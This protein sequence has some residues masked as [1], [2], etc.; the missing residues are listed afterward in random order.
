MKILRLTLIALI[1]LC[2]ACE[3]DKFEF[4]DCNGD[5]CIQSSGYVYDKLTKEPITSARIKISYKENCGWCGTGCQFREFNIGEV[6]T[7]KSGY[8][9]T[10]FSSK[11]FD[12]ITGNYV[13]EIFY[14]DFIS[15]T[16]GISN[17]NQSELFFE[18]DLNPPAYLNLSVNLQNTLNIEYFGLSIYSDSLT[19]RSLGGYNSNESGLFTDTVLNF[20][21]PAERKIYYGYLIKTNNGEKYSNDSTII[22]SYKTKDLEINE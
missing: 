9:Q 18:A 11:E 12:G 19:A 20:I 13:F 17:D 1:F 22:D 14:E 6:L 15:E 10:N 16:I 4:G 3:K 2:N 8:F 5:N 7:D 21:V